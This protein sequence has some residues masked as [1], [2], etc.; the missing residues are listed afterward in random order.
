VAAVTPLCRAAPRAAPTAPISALALAQLRHLPGHL[1]ASVA[2]IVS[3]SLC[4]ASDHCSRSRLV[5]AV[6]ARHRGRR[7]LRAPPRRRHGPH[8]RTG[9]ASWRSRRGARRAVRFDR[10]VVGTGSTP[11]PGRA[12]HRQPILRGFEVEPRDPVSRGRAS[13]WYGSRR[14]ATSRLERRRSHHA[15]W[16]GAR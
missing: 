14:R 6:A 3:A 4:V 10:I 1:A 12:A 2:G 5:R 11:S 7:P 9:S 8:A 13:G 15:R 16:R